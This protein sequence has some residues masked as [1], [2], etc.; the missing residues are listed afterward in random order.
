MKLSGLLVLIVFFCPI[1]AHAQPAKD[2]IKIEFTTSTRGYYKQLTMTKQSI[3]IQQEGRQ[4][5]NKNPVIRKMKK[6]DWNRL[7]LSL[8]DVPLAE[9]PL[10]K[11]PS[12]NRASDGARASSIA[13]TT[14][15]GVIWSHEF[16]NENPHEKLQMLMKAITTLNK[17]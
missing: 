6:Q 17:D 16:D 1:N 11:S 14:S 12:S 13:I 4:S 7:I 3:T 8:K 10:L 15:D 5:E 9:L 2:I